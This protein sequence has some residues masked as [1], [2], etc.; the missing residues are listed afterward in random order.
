MIYD[1]IPANEI[2]EIQRRGRDNEIEA[3]KFHERGSDKRPG[4]EILGKGGWNICGHS[5][6]RMI[7]RGLCA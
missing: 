6:S 2:Y 3:V 5:H 7:R 1:K 4:D